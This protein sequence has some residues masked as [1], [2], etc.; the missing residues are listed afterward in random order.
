[1]GG[2]DYSDEE[3]HEQWVPL[4]TSMLWG[5]REWTLLSLEFVLYAARNPSAA[6]KLAA[7]ERTSRELL[8]PIVEQ[9]IAVL[10]TSLDL[11]AEELVE[12]FF[13]LFNGISMRHV[14]DPESG[15]EQLVETSIKFLMHALLGE[16]RENS[17]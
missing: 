2:A 9:Q 14:T 11:A 17:P 5:D 7:L 4:T 13:A 15:S 1:M 6:R 16:S 3:L 8:V 10:G 12:I